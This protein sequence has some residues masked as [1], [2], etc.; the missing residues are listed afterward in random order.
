[1]DLRK[2]PPF[3]MANYKRKSV[4]I[5]VHMDTVEEG[6]FAY[7]QEVGRGQEAFS[8]TKYTSDQT[9]GTREYDTQVYFNKSILTRA[10]ED[11][12]NE[13]G[14]IAQEIIYSPRTNQ[15]L[16]GVEDGGN[17]ILRPYDDHTRRRAAMYEVFA[18][19]DKWGKQTV[20]EMNNLEKKINEAKTDKTREKYSKLLDKLNEKLSKKGK[21]RFDYVLRKPVSLHSVEEAQNIQAEQNANDRIIKEDCL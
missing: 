16:K 3:L 6:G 13:D 1:M 4:Y 21:Y 14:E 5:R 8:T 10:R 11:M 7:Y 2:N 9:V 19:V 17:M 20:R 12:Y 15:K 18:I